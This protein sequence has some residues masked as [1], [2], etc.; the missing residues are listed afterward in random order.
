M[1]FLNFDVRQSKGLVY[2]QNSKDCKNVLLI[3]NTVNDAQLFSASVN[4]STMPITYSYNSTKTELLALLKSNFTAIDR[5]AI[6]FTSGFG[7]SKIFL[8]NKSFF[9]SENIDF[10]VSLI[11]ELGVKN[12]DFL[13]CNTLKYSNWKEYYKGLTTETQVIVG[14]SNDKTGNIKYGGDWIMENSSENI[15]TVYF[16]KSII[17][18]SYLL[19]TNIPWA[20]GFD[21]PVGLAIY[22]GYMYVA[23]T[24]ISSPGTT[25]SKINLANGNIVDASW[26]T[27]LDGPVGLA[28]Y[29]GYMYVA[30]AGGFDPGTTISKINMEN[31]DILD[32]IWATGLNGPVGL[33]IYEGCMYVSNYGIFNPGT[34]IS[35]INL[36]NG[37]IIEANWA[38]GLNAPVALAI[39]EGYMYVSNY[40]F[41]D[42]G[43]TI[44]KINLA[45]GNII[46]ASWANGLNGPFGLAIYE[47]YMYVANTGILN[48]GT[49]ISK[50][51]LAN[52]DVVNPSW[53]TGLNRPVA[54]IIYG[55]YIYVTALDSNIYRFLLLPIAPICFPKGTPI[56]TDQ[57]L[58]PI[59]KIDTAIHSI[60]NKRIVSITQT[61]TNESYLVC[62]EKHS[63]GYNYPSQRTIMSQQH[64]VFFGGK[65]IPAYTF[66]RLFNNIKKVKYNGELLYNVLMDKHNKM[67]VN[68]LLCET[69]HPD[70]K[71]AKLYANKTIQ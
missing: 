2:S 16:S 65:M 51:N 58:I 26:A 55:Q 56:R 62:F 43:T 1:S 7:T 69:L 13:G 23:N 60:N 34:T 32:A 67:K 12:I 5:I 17:Y 8:D 46:E 64:K 14:A 59:D 54:L 44:S 33:T 21:G 68:N 45:D 38:T 11:K 20:T 19:D 66:I 57:G 22:E 50:I 70:H 37:D 36:E 27:G 40:G 71:V 4:S 48:P 29:E 35:K 10:L 15:E 49:T 53:A 52:G 47:G 31:G 6:C 3:D 28:I 61:T 63:L 9:D 30:N 41:S 25:I 42:A 24:G 39:Y 18:Y